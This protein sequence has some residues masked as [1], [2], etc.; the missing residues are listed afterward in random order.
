MM[1]ETPIDLAHA[2]MM[3]A[4]DDPAARLRFYERVGDAELFLLLEKEA[5]GDAIAPQIFDL[6]QASVVLA[7]DREER[8][9]DFIGRAAPYAAV[10]GRALMQMLQGQGLG[11]GLNLEVAPSSFLLDADGIHWLSETL[12]NAPKEVSAEIAELLAPSGLPETLI[13]SIDKKLAIA[14]GLASTA[15]LVAVR[16]GDGGRGHMIALIDVAAGAD[17]ALAQAMSEALTFSGIEAGSLDVGCFVST[18][19]MTVRL[20]RVGLRFDLPQIV[21]TPD[22][23]PLAPGSDPAKPP[24]LK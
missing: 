5:D 8:I 12:N 23:T 10:S 2:A 16:Y 14:A 11:L 17:E 24:I 13:A 3:A 21:P 4:P 19:P 22:R 20:A 9:S 18:D 1:P 6:P 7:F 15:Y